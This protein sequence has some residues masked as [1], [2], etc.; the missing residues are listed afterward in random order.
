MRAYRAGSREQPTRQLDDAIKAAARRAV[1]ARPHAAAVGSMAGQGRR[2]WPRVFAVAATVV[3]T[4]SLALVTLRERDALDRR[5][6]APPSSAPAAAAP[7]EGVAD[8]P[9]VHPQPP[10][11]AA[12]VPAPASRVE[13]LPAPRTAVPIRSEN[14]VDARSAEA[15]RDSVAVSS[16]RRSSVPPPEPAPQVPQRSC[17]TLFCQAGVGGVVCG[18]GAIP[19]S[20]V[21]R[22]YRCECPHA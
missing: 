19:P 18:F 5:Q 9:A 8:S 12:P 3:L 20:M 17:T 11:A 6:A 10:T 14:S 7:A 15:R 4:T 13:A 16:A 1:G 2:H 22:A 21:L